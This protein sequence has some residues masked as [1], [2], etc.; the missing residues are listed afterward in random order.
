[1][2]QQEQQELTLPPITEW[3]TAKALAAHFGLN[4]ESA[5]RWHDAGLI[6]QGLIRYCGTR[7]LRFHPATREALEKKF[8]E[9]RQ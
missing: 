6:P 9:R 3:L 1:M 2:T 5:Y 7:R 8:A 4:E